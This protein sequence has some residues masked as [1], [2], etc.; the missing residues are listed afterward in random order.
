MVHSILMLLHSAV[1][2][3]KPSY[4]PCDTRHTGSTGRHKNAGTSRP[5]PVLGQLRGWIFWQ[6]GFGKFNE[7]L[8]LRHYGY[9]VHGNN[10]A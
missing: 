6:N 3:H 10:L 7:F 4:I 1:L 2:D 5:G 9:G 8:S